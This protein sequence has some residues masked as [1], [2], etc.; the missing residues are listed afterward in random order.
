MRAAQRT[1]SVIKLDDEGAT[2]DLWGPTDS[3]RL[4]DAAVELSDL[5]RERIRTK[6]KRLRAV[7]D[8]KILVLDDQYVYSELEMFS[9][10]ELDTED[11]HSFHSI[12]VARSGR[13]SVLLTSGFANMRGIWGSSN[14]F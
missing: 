3:M 1:C 8:T 5:I 4:G 14:A 7:H 11:L 9:T 13:Q 10:L 6:R 2:L 12:Y